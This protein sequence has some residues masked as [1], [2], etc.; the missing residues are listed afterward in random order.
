V[1]VG[2]GVGVGLGLPPDDPAGVSDWIPDPKEL[3][4]DAD[5]AV[6]EIL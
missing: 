6:V 4:I 1:G 5:K 2:V 3:V